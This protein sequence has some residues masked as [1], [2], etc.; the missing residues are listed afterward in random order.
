MANDVFIGSVEDYKIHQEKK[1]SEILSGTNSDGSIRKIAYDNM[2]PISDDDLKILQRTINR[3]ETNV[4]YMQSEIDFYDEFYHSDNSE[5]EELLREAKKIRR[6]YKSLSKYL[7]AVHVRD[8]Y[9]DSL[10]D[11]YDGPERFNMYISLGLVKEWIPPNPIFSKSSPE[12]EQYKLGILDIESIDFVDDDLLNEILEDNLKA[13]G[14]NVD[15]IGIIGDVVTDQMGI[16]HAYDT[17]AVSS[18]YTGRSTNTAINGV[19][20]DDLIGLQNMF[21]DWYRPKPEI[22]S[23]ASLVDNMFQ[24]TPT[25]IR[26]RFYSAPI[27]DMGNDKFGT[28]IVEAEPDPNEMV[29]DPKLNRPM[30]RRE[31]DQREVIRMW[32][33]AGWSEIR[34]MRYLEVGSKY[35]Q[36]LMAKKDKNRKRANKKAKNVVNDILGGGSS[37]EFIDSTEE[38]R[39]LLFG[40]DDYR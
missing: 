21:R 33:K 36:Q 5:D 10:V 23:D 22:T 34:L 6:V 16:N 11:K 31:R 28:K 19:S 35:E 39:G 15:D 25:K 18:S 29:I 30:T 13:E 14:I 27:V 24:D 17:N 26:E 4:V 7:Y 3:H 40:D 2:D 32:A 38:L 8:L 12:Y 9:L 20:A 37:M 1:R